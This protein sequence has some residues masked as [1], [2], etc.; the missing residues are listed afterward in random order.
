MAH[1]RISVVVL[2]HGDSLKKAVTTHILGQDLSQV[3][4]KLDQLQNEIYENDTH[5]V[6]CT[7]DVNNG[8]PEAIKELFTF[9]KNPDKCLLVVQG[10]VTMDEVWKQIERLS[11]TT[12]KLTKE[13]TVVP[14][15]YRQNY[16]FKLYTMGQIF[17]GQRKPAED[18]PQTKKRPPVPPESNV[19][20]AGKLP[21]NKVNLVLLGL[22]GTGKSASGNTIL[23]QKLF[24]SN[25]SSQPVTTECQMGETQINGT[26][27]RV[28][29]TP[30]I[31]DDDMHQS[32]KDQHVAKCKLLCQAEPCVYLLV[33]QDHGSCFKHNYTLKFNTMG[34]CLIRP[35]KRAGDNYP[36]KNRPTA[37]T[38]SNLT[39]GDIYNTQ[40]V[41]DI[42]KSSKTGK[43]PGNKVNLVLLGL[44]GTGKSASGNTILGQKPF[45]S[46]LSSQPVTTECQMV[47]TQINAPKCGF[48]KGNEKIV[49]LLDRVK[50]E[51]V[52]LRETIITVSSWIQH[53][54][55]KI[56]DG[57]DFGVAIQEKILER[58]AAV[59]TKVDGFQ[60]NINKYFSERGDAVAKASKETHVM[61][62]RS[63]VHEKDQAIY[64]EIRV[65]VLDIRGF[66][67]TKEF[68]GKILVVKDQSHC[69]EFTRRFKVWSK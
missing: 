16:A 20:T 54:I 40:N 29:D 66:Y 9:I 13:F 7:T 30:D 63:L 5:E 34:L 36:T 58:I 50:P 10:G 6:T 24:Q 2:G 8:S 23:G 57:N 27:V 55:P 52:A 68:T 31:F 19:S 44:A 42:K 41:T 12:G 69:E 38:E 11:M 45:Q 37:P 28:I 49:Q 14:V 56:E 32:L 15:S 21:G 46:N 64:A 4:R 51:I 17:G 65:I 33:M 62:Y 61:D 59:K 67:Q 35:R 18:R 60:T 47:E 39:T 48:I 22:A 1:D 26:C 43:L 3:S 53:L 25:L